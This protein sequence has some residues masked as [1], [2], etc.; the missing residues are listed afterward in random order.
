MNALVDPASITM[1]YEASQA[2]GNS[3]GWQMDGT[4]R[5]ERC[6]TAGMTLRAQ[7]ELIATWPSV[8]RKRNLFQQRSLASAQ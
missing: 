1:L 3:S 6:H 4:G 7:E 2:E 8:L 5:Y